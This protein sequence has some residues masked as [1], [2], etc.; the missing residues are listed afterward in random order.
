VGE[1]DYLASPPSAPSVKA[2]RSLP[3]AAS[4]GLS[5]SIGTGITSVEF[6]SA[7]TSVIV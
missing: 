1:V 6:F 7:E 3:K 5:S 4:N 2:D